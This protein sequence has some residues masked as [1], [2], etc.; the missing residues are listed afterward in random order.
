MDSEDTRHQELLGYDEQSETWYVQTRES[1][2]LILSRQS[3]AR[4]VQLYNEIHKGSP[5]VLLEQRELRRMEETRQ[6]QSETLRDLY[7]FLD[8]KERRRPLSIVRRFL[9]RVFPHSRKSSSN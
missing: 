1:G 2:R 3:L 9:G 7:L 6:R 4:L 5:F 8:R